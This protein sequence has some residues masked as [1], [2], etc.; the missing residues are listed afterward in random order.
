MDAIK[1]NSRK[2]IYGYYPTDVYMMAEEGDRLFIV[3][4]NNINW[5]MNIGEMLYF[6]RIVYGDD[7]V[8][9]TAT[10][11]VQIL[12]KTEF[13]DENGIWDAMYTTLPPKRKLYLKDRNYDLKIIS[14]STSA[15]IHTL[16]A[17]SEDAPEVSGITSMSIGEGYFDPKMGY[18]IVMEDDGLKIDDSVMHVS[19]K[20]EDNVEYEHFLIRFNEP[21]G[22]YQQDIA[23]ANDY[24]SGF[25]LCAFDMNGN[26]IG[27]IDGVSIPFTGIPMTVTS[28]DT[29]TY[30]GYDTCGKYD[31]SGYPYDFKVYTYTYCP[32]SFSRNA[33]LFTSASTIG[34]YYPSGE[35]IEDNYDAAI[36]LIEHASY[37]EPVYN[38]YYYTFMYSEDLRK[39]CTMWG[40]PWWPILEANNENQP[41]KVVYERPG[42]SHVELTR[43]SGYWKVPFLAFSSEDMIGTVVN[44]ESDLVYAQRIM[45]AAIPDVIDMEK[46]K[47][48]PHIDYGE[49]GLKPAT[50]IT[51]DFHFRKREEIDKESQ[52]AAKAIGFDLDYSP[53]LDGWNINPDSAATI[54]W[55]GM[56]YEEAT[57]SPQ[58]MAEFVEASGK[59]SDMIGVLDF[60]DSDIMY[61]K[62]KVSKSFLRFSYYTSKDPVEQKLLYYSTSFLDT[63][64]LYGK[65]MKQF[66]LRA[67]L[68]GKKELSVP[69]VFFDNNSASA[70][71]DT[72]IVIENE[73]NMM[74]SS[75][76]FNIYLFKDDAEK[77]DS[78]NTYRTI[79]MKVEF[80]HAGNG[81]T[82][83]MII[84]P[85]DDNGYSALT[86]SNFMQNLYIP[87]RVQYID[88]KYVYTIPDAI[89][90]DGNIR[91]VLFEPKLE[92]N[93]GAS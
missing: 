44:D 88:E 18:L 17:F 83:P 37:F 42:I 5:K 63:T 92:Y 1:V 67:S 3:F 23:A 54:W 81:K 16:L 9:E 49:D 66:L 91:L 19:G 25:S 47:Y 74:A 50:S 28:A 31:I 39:R 89:N 27:Y 33:I 82:I 57:F 4:T 20:T 76:G 14:A 30:S 24:L 69:I 7:G 13:E 90:E 53:Y 71:L 32:S 41:R 11:P 12:E 70:R 77:V 40:D 87:V 15:D 26:R 46:V 35:V 38:E 6:R 73:Y 62:S 34:K 79:Y 51:F 45:D 61:R 8:Y 86:V 80:N 48:S 65:F 52:E 84:W 64:A 21:H 93:D 78:G 85:H 58:K 22:I 55:N 56:D 60:T 36:Y 10:S 2:K 72:E 29:L 59:V 75:E 43:Y 68:L